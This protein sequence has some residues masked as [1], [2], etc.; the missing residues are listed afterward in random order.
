LVRETCK[1]YIVR[2]DIGRLNLSDIT[3]DL[4]SVVR[5]VRTIGLLRVLVPFRSKYAF[6]TNPF[7]TSTQTS[8]TRKK[9]NEP[10]C[11]RF[12]QRVCVPF[13]DAE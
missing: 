7:E 1:Q 13:G 9:V 10:K 2:R 8:D 5:E 3:G 6:S 11:R 4:V 12:R